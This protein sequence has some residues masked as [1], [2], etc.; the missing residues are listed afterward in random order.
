VGVYIDQ[1]I[2]NGKRFLQIID[3]MV[4]P[5]KFK[6]RYTLF[7]RDFAVLQWKRG[8]KGGKNSQRKPL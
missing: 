3:Q 4:I 1:A 6:T 5:A 8:A 7:A 2:W